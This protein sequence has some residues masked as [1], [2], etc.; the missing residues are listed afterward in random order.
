MTVTQTC[1]LLEKETF[2]QMAQVV[3]NYL[4]TKKGKSQ[5]KPLDVL[6]KC[7]KPWKRL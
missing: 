3:D 1:L 7:L 6:I 4:P 5:E 2:H